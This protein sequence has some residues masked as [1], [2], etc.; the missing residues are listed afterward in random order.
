MSKQN[1]RLFNNCHHL[2]DTGTPGQLP[3]THDL[4]QGLCHGHLVDVPY[5]LYMYLSDI[6]ST[7][8]TL[9]CQHFRGLSHLNAINN[10]TKISGILEDSHRPIKCINFVSRLV[11]G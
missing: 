8:G 6:V 3:Q 1:L 10:I 9:R 2:A 11:Q 7:I 5:L 4:S